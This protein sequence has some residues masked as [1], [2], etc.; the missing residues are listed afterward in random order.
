VFQAVAMDQSRGTLRCG[1]MAPG[2]VS[3]WISYWYP[4]KLMPRVSGT[5][6]HLDVFTEYGRR[7]TRIA[8][9]YIEMRSPSRSVILTDHDRENPQRISNT[10]SP[11]LH[12]SLPCVVK[13]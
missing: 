6:S 4:N 10:P 13:I 5:M 9:V 1:M 3:D 8:R 7:G 11:P 2:V 12:S